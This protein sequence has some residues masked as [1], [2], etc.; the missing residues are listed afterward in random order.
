M[1]FEFSFLFSLLFL[2]TPGNGQK[3]INEHFALGELC[4]EEPPD[5]P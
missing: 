5:S 4:V 2:Q 3:N 1:T